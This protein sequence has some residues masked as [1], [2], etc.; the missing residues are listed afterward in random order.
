MKALSILWISWTIVLASGC[1]SRREK[2]TTP[3]QQQFQAQVDKSCEG[4]E[5]VYEKT[6]VDA[7]PSA[8][9]PLETLKDTLLDGEQCPLQEELAFVVEQV[10]DDPIAL[11]KYDTVKIGD[12]LIA[13]I[14]PGSPQ[15]AE[16][17]LQKIIR[18]DSSQIRY[19][20]S[21]TAGSSW[22]YETRITAWVRFDSL[23]RY[24][25]HEV[26]SF[27]EVATVKNAFQAS[28]KGKVLAY[29]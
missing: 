13:R 16:L 12:T 1:G 22:L 29:E 7:S 21:H 28:I 6:V 2:P 27:M 23:G 4:R 11:D 18:D 19:I 20:E 25:E 15:S 9:Q 10:F 3:L 17:Q 14:K 5:W 8:Q 24:A 26:R